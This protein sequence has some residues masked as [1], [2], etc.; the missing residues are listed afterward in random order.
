MLLVLNKTSKKSSE[1]VNITNMQQGGWTNANNTST[2]N[3]INF[4]TGASSSTI[5]A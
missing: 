5:V 4:K 3:G 2:P 1:V